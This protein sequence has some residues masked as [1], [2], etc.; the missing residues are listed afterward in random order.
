L[1]A[2]SFEEAE[3]FVRQFEVGMKMPVRVCPS[4]R[5]LSVIEPGFDRRLLVAI[6][7]AVWFILVGVSALNGLGK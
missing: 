2:R 4:K 3:Q 7:F 6:G 1:S 5:R